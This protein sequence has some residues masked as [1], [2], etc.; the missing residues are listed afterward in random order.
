MTPY[1][2]LG[3]DSGIPSYEIGSTSI[4]VQFNTGATYPYDYNNPGSSHVEQMKL[5]ARAGR[6]LNSYIGKNVRSNY[7]AKLN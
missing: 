1:Q 5:L 6:V 4:T 2:N 7:A 3:R